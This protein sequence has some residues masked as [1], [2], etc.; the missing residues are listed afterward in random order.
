M[1]PRRRYPFVIESEARDA[2]HH[3]FSYFARFSVDEHGVARVQLLRVVGD[4]RRAWQEVEGEGEARSFEARAD[5]PSAVSH[6]VVAGACTVGALARAAAAIETLA[7]RAGATLATELGAGATAAAATV[8]LLGGDETGLS[9][10]AL[11]SSALELAAKLGEPQAR[12]DALARVTVE[13]LC[14]LDD[15]VHKDDHP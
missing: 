13:V 3:E 12:A 10:D 15:V 11:A 5:E 4:E 8:R 14:H 1:A 7:T 6:G 2:P 9:Y